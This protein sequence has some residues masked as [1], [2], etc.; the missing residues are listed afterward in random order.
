MTQFKTLDEVLCYLKVCFDVREAERLTYGQASDR[1]MGLICSA[2]SQCDALAQERN[3]GV[4]KCM[5][6]D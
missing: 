6:L 5:K 3:K 1:I 4:Q 2:L